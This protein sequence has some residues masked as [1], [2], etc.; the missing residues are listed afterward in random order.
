MHK[1]FLPREPPVINS[2]PQ[3]SSSPVSQRK[4]S[5]K[6]RQ[7]DVDTIELPSDETPRGKRNRTVRDERPRESVGRPPSG[8]NSMPP[9]ISRPSALHDSLRSLLDQE[10]RVGRNSPIALAESPSLEYNRL[11]AEISGIFQGEMSKLRREVRSTGD[12]TNARLDALNVRLDTMAS[13]PN[14]L[15]PQATEGRDICENFNS[16]GGCT[17]NRCM[18]EHR[19][20]IC[21]LPDHPAT[22]HT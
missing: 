3:D 9:I 16:R 12:A 11:L 13:R 6:R 5:L 18:H 10:P 14:V 19:C 20:S 4:R 15:Q 2:L 7:V 21:L 8:L 17:W 22:R 1:S